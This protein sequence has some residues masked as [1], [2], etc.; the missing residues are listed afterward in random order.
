VDADAA[1][2]LRAGTGTFQIAVVIIR[3]PS[4][5]ARIRPTLTVSSCTLPLVAD[6]SPL[7]T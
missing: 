5:T 1:D 7:L 6:P 3:L 2:L 4:S